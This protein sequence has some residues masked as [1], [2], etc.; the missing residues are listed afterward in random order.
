M[1]SALVGKSSSYSSRSISGTRTISSSSSRSISGSR[2]ISGSSAMS[3]SGGMQMLGGRQTRMS[4]GSTI[5]GSTP[6]VYGG[7]G[8]YGTRISQS[9][10]SFG[11][12]SVVGFNDSVVIGNEKGTMQNLNDRLASYLVKVKSLS[13]ANGKLEM[14]IRE[15]CEQRTYVSRDLD[16]YFATIADLQAQ[17]QRR[18][19]ENQNVMLQID[20]ARLAAEDFKMKYEMELN[21]RTM[22]EADLSRFRGIRDSVTLNISDLEMQIEGLREELV[23]MKSSHKEELLLLRAQQSGKVNVEVDSSESVDLLK[24]LEEIREHYETMV[25]KNK[26]EVE[27]WFQEK[28]SGLEVV[29]VSTSTEVK[30][31]YTQLS[32]LKRT[33]QS[34]EINRQS[35]ITEF[36]CL[37]QSLEE[38]N[39][40]Y[41]LQLSQLQMTINVLEEELQRLIVSIEQQQT[42]YT[43]LLDIKMRLEREIAE[44]RRLLEGEVQEK[45]TVIISKVEEV[46]EHK[47][48]IERRVKTI[49]E[50]IVDG[51]VVSSSVDTQVEEIQ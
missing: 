17:V 50:E 6:S 32:E 3:L 38:A 46:E 20:N 26:Q 18:R 49:V 13:E 40:R 30:T 42:E 15:F 41:S 19:L 24:T 39:S 4:T 43:L 9:A 51:K 27:K 12:G 47:P 22:V 23:Y 8:G 14:Q 7:A 16:G 33:Y 29:L 21:L 1:T 2:T 44:Y 5:L 31:Y 37:Q 28:M 34:L 45:R 10:F 36:Q 35:V 11:S 48:H 25:L